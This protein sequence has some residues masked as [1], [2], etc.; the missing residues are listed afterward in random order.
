M[1]LWK[2]VI[3][4]NLALG[5]GVGLGYVRW[6]REVRGLQDEVARLRADATRAT[7]QSWT[8]RGIVRSIIP[9]LGAVFLTHEA[10]PGLMD[11]MTMGF[12]TDNPKLLDGL[13]PGDAVRFTVRREGERLVLVAIEKTKTP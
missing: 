9:K 7:P 3:L 11:A 2:V 5:V 8:V 10:L 13:K 6:A 12:E 1:R 4:L